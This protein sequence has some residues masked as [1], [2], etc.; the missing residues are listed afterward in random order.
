MRRARRRIERS[1]IACTSVN[2][3][4]SYAFEIRTV[5]RNQIRLRSQ[6]AS[7]S[8]LLTRIVESRPDPHV[9]NADV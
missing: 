8:I 3:A 5:T 7:D 4:G 1:L 9:R 2:L 6:P